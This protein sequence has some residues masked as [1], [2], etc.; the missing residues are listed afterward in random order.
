MLGSPCLKDLAGKFFLFLPLYLIES[1]DSMSIK[2]IFALA[3]LDN[4][5]YHLHGHFINCGVGQQWRLQPTAPGCVS[6]TMESTVACEAGKPQPGFL[7][8]W[9]V[10][11]H[12]IHIHHLNLNCTVN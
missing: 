7:L 6:Q 1:F 9:H 11:V 10:N 2:Y 8:K 12:Q 5:F 3:E 4:K